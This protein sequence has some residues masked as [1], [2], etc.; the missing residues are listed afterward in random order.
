M[1]GMIYILF[2][3]HECV[4]VFRERVGKG[5]SK[6]N[7]VSFNFGSKCVSGN[8]F[9]MW[10]PERSGKLIYCNDLHAARYLQ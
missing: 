3:I 2:H 10:K 7:V 9:I 4:C 1:Y 5:K 6:E 8:V